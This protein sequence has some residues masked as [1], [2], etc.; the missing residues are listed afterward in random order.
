M[1]IYVIVVIFLMN[2][3]TSNGIPTYFWFIQMPI[4]KK[5]SLV[6]YFIS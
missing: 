5:Q 3:F 6:L 4:I 1:T 2:K